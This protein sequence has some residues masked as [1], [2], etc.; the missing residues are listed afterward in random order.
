[1]GIGPVIIN[2]RDRL[3]ISN[4]DATH[5]GISVIIICHEASVMHSVISKDM[6]NPPSFKNNI[7]V[8]T[9]NVVVTCCATCSEI[10]GIVLPLVSN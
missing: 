1:M 6:R 8:M 4:N 7:F 9:L 5:K 2:N 3:I 10:V